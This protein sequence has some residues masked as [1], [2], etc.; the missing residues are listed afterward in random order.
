MN[1]SCSSV[2]FLFGSTSSATLSK[3]TTQSWMETSGKTVV[4]AAFQARSSSVT[5][6]F[7]A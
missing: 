2:L 6:T 1:S 4:T 3:W 7:G 5:I